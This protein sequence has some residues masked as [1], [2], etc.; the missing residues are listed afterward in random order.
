M[1]RPRSRSCIFVDAG[2]AVTRVSVRGAT[3][4][5]AWLC[6]GADITKPRRCA[7]ALGPV[8]TKTAAQETVSRKSKQRTV[9]VLALS[10][11]RSCYLFYQTPSKAVM[12]AFHRSQGQFASTPRT[13]T[14]L[15]S[16]T[17]AFALSPGCAINNGPTEVV[18]AVTEEE[19]TPAARSLSVSPAAK[20]VRLSGADLPASYCPRCSA[21]LEARKCKMICTSCGYYMSCSDFH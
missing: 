2:L 6:V 12:V 11:T 17:R 3:R 8:R 1:G 18:F 9:D 15:A 16:L 10:I 14:S 20:P 5:T 13:F 7:I 4:I 19:R 21:K